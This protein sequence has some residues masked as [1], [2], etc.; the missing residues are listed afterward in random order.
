MDGL[1]TLF[2]IFAR[3]LNLSLR[4]EGRRARVYVVSPRL[5][6]FFIFPVAQFQVA[7]ASCLYVDDARSLP[8]VPLAV[9]GVR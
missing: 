8:F 3:P 6:P 2:C 4:A 1:N 7:R 9:M 5:F